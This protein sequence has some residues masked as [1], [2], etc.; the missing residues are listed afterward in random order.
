MLDVI[1]LFGS[2]SLLAF[3][4]TISSCLCA[5]YPLYVGVWDLFSSCPRVGG[6]FN[7]QV[8]KGIFMILGLFDKD[9]SADFLIQSMLSYQKKGY[10]EHEAQHCRWK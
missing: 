8:K 1:Y 9:G 4:L 2:F 10:K 3:F 6:C 7:C 5:G